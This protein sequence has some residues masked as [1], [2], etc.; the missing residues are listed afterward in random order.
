[1]GQLELALKLMTIL[2]DCETAAGQQLQGVLAL[3]L[4]E[5]NLVHE[6]RRVQQISEEE[7]LHGRICR[8]ALCDSFGAEAAGAIAELERRE[9]E[10]SHF[11]TAFNMQLGS[12]TETVIFTALMDLAAL[13]IISDFHQSSFKP[14]GTLAR[15]LLQDEEGHIGF[16]WSRM[17]QVFEND[18]EQTVSL[19]QKWLQL[20]LANFGRAGSEYDVLKVKYGLTGHTAAQRS[21][22]YKDAVRKKLQASLREPAGMLLLVDQP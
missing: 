1:M 5:F 11:I 21:E 3:N 2:A 9:K 8:T 14:F 10:N 15:R 6:R 7:F 13:Y 4:P 17:Q 19:F 20:A 18:V 22:K 12:F 16:G